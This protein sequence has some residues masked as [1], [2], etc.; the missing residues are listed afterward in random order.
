MKLNTN[1]IEKELKRLGKSKGW[2]AKKMNVAPPMVS[3]IMREKP[4][5][6]AEKIGKILDIDP[7]DLIK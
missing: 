7:K 4:I 3:Y 5:T 1:K 6:Q 2:L